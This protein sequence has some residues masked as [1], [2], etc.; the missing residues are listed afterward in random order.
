VR[1]VMRFLDVDDTHPVE[2]LDANPSI[3]LRSQQLD[4]LVHA[5][6]VGRGPVSRVAKAAMKALAPGDARRRLLGVTRRRVVHAEPKAPDEKLM[7]ELRIRFKPEVVALSEYLDRDMVG[8]WGY[9]G[10]A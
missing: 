5:V 1:R 9:D 8:L 10:V 2:V 6:S 4:D 7:R 3:L